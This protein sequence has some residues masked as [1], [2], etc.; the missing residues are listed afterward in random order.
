MLE[1]NGSFTLNAP[2]DNRRGTACLVEGNQNTH[3]AVCRSG[4]PV[5]PEGIW[6][7]ELLGKPHRQ[8]SPAEA[9][10]VPIT[11]GGSDGKAVPQRASIR[12]RF[13]LT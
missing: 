12:I 7:V 5:S 9:N 2:A 6:H 8:L 1:D 11:Q 10:N 4:N 13:A 3:S